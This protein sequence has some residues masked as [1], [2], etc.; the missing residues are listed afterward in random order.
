MTRPS[1]RTRGLASHP[2]LALFLSALGVLLLLLT[3]NDFKL[4]ADTPDPCAPPNGNPV[5]CENQNP[6]APAAEWDVS[7]AGDD[8]IQGFATDISVQR[9][10]PIDLKIDRDAASYGIDIYRRGY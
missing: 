5:V 1:R 6:G 8:S 2:R 10:H 9:E 4:R 7:G 3:A